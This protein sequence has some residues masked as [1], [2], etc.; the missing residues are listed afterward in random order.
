MAGIML[1]PFKHLWPT[2]GKRR[3]LRPIEEK[4]RDFLRYAYGVR[5]SE[6]QK[7]DKDLQAALNEKFA[8]VYL[9]DPLEEKIT[10]FLYGPA[11]P[12]YCHAPGCEWRDGEFSAFHLEARYC[13]R[14]SHC[15]IRTMKTSGGWQDISRDDY[16]FL[17]EQDT[18][19][20]AQWGS[21]RE[22]GNYN[23]YENSRLAFPNQVSASMSVASETGEPVTSNIASARNE[24][25]RY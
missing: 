25:S 6:Y 11:R 9:R 13:V 22:V 17:F 15:Q 5:L 20:R 23:P 19:H 8:F 24:P 1:R 12:S 4:F 18:A 21:A 7:M 3:A 16:E 2:F 14:C 10:Q